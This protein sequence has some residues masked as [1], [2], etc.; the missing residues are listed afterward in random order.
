MGKS[1]EKA[2]R[3]NDGKVDWSQM[4]YKSL[5]PMIRVLEFGAKKYAKKN[6]M[7]EMDLFQILNSMQRH[8]AAIM[9]GEVMDPESGLP[10]M[11]HV[12]CNAMFYNY[13]FLKKNNEWP[14][15]EKVYDLKDHIHPIGR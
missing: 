10:H 12:Q 5:E 11:G 4:H 8:M 6:W 15:L 7:K 9:D 14:E 1:K 2:M 13:H 3:F